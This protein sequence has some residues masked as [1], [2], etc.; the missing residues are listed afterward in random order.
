MENDG[1]PGKVITEFVEEHN[2]IDNWI[3][4]GVGV[5]LIVFGLAATHVSSPMPGARPGYPAPL[6]IK[7]ILVSFGA[8][9]VVMGIAGLLHK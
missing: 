2:L 7:A 4:V 1:E 3:T 5:V 9:A 6:R 8:I